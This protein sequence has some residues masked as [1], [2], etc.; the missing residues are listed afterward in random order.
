M[1]LT[2]PAKIVEIHGT[3]A[4]VEIGGIRKEVS[5]AM[6]TEVNV[7]D[8]VLSASGV[9]ISKISTEEAAELLALLT[10]MNP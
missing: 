3:V 10:P 9:A 7:G 8:F 2:V 5:I 1:C 6:L 4:V